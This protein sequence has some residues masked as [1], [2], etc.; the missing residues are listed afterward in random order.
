MKRHLDAY[1]SYEVKY[2]SK[3]V[4]GMEVRQMI[5]PTVDDSIVS[6]TKCKVPGL[7]IDKYKAFKS[8]IVKHTPK[9]DKKLSMTRLA[10]VEG[11]IV[12]HTHV[13]MPMMLTDRSVFN[14]Y[15]QYET[16]DGCWIDLCSKNGADPAIESAEGKKIH[17]KNVFANNHCD[18]RLI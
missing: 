12:T 2:T 15:F 7:T 10:D 11:H 6:I 16:D 4:E 1:D 5:D 9:L 14:L 3:L 8:E 13:K 17:G 18:Y